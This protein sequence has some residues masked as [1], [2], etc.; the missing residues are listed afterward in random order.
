MT[1]AS[2]SAST[3]QAQD[4]ANQ[5]HFPFQTTQKNGT[6]VTL[7]FQ[8]DDE[9]HWYEDQNGYTVVESGGEYRYAA[10]G[11][12]GALVATDHLVGAVNPARQ[13]LVP[14]TLPGAKM[15]SKLRTRSRELKASRGVPLNDRVPSDSTLIDGCIMVKNSAMNDDFGTSGSGPQGSV[16]ITSGTW[17]NGV[18]YYAFD[19][20]V[21]TT[22]KSAMLD[23]MTSWEAVA[24][25]DFVQRT[26]QA[27]YIYIFNG[28]GNW[29]YVGMIGGRQDLSI[30]NWDYKY[31]MMHELAHAL[32]FWH[33]QSRGDRDTYVQINLG[34]VQA[35]KEHN[36]DI[37]AGAQD[38]GAYD[39]DSIMHYGQC[40]FA[41]CTCSSA[42]RTITC[43]A[44]NQA[45]QDQIGQKTHLSVG[46][47]ENMA[48]MYGPPANPGMA[49]LTTPSSDGA[50][51][52]NGSQTFTWT[53]G[54]G[55]QQYRLTAG[56]GPGLGNYYDQSG[57]STTATVTGLPIEG[58]N[59]HV[60]LYTRISG[61]WY[62]K[63]YTY[64][65]DLCG[66]FPDNVDA[67]YDGMPDGCDRCPGF[68]DSADADSDGVPDGCDACPGHDD[69]AD[70]DSDGIP[71][72][73]D[74]CPTGAGNT[75]TDGDGVPDACDKCPGK[76]DNADAD[77]DGTPDGCDL[78]PGHNDAADAD[79]DGI[80]D[81]CDVC[82][83]GDDSIDTDN[84]G[85]PNACDECP[86]VDNRIDRDDDG[87]PDCLDECPDDPAKFT[88]GAC[89]CGEPETDTDGDG[90]PDCNDA[91]PLDPSKLAPG[92]DGCNATVPITGGGV[93]GGG[94][95][96]AGGMC[97]GGAALPLP[98]IMMSLV[99]LQKRHR[100]RVVRHR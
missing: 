18:I 44:P 50:L 28:T 97:G 72:A 26:N 62:W 22:Q 58:G 42:C 15:I 3:L 23:A 93:L 100:R 6:V 5:H 1:L 98:A 87:F 11:A 53:T 55:A 24:N 82:P 9:F 34:N 89:G 51:I 20:A 38:L 91:C 75:D 57:T 13:G 25:V 47:A 33:E 45:W 37:Q 77:N 14:H 43:L 71:D 17:T 56:S 76:N 16:A 32:G 73:C 29:S 85:T 54:S 10:L 35:G 65:T 79:Q 60:R 64:I 8:G 7:T 30:Y 66:G 63:S 81:A 99:C 36:F 46:D 90:T 68:N 19:A 88:A 78:C 70:L 41:N 49:Q 59:V 52:K 84:D 27:N 94:P 21:N 61:T 74:V 86:G 67:D 31:I 80:P 39:F 12:D 95:T 92:T 40:A 48:L 2:F 4:V 96:S 69:N 83:A